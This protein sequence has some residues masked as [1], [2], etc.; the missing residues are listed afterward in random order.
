VLNKRQL[1]FIEEYCVDLNATQAAIRAGYSE[2][3][4]C[5]IGV[6]NLSKP[7]IKTEI[8][9]ILKG[10]SEE[11]GLTAKMVL[12]E[13]KSIAFDKSN[14]VNDRIRALDL[15]GKHLKLFTYKVEAEVN[16][17]T[18]IKVIFDEKLKEWA[19]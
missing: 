11:T 12:D 14:K 4:A 16:T 19:Q 6:E 18:E 1:R 2:K 5:S 8:D 10:R 13:L 3:T 9:K 15:L 7:H 17:D